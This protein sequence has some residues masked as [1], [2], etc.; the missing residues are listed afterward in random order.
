MANGSIAT[1]KH[2]PALASKP[3][4]AEIVES[5]WYIRFGVW[6]GTL[7][8]QPEIPKGWGWNP[9]VITLCI[10]VLSLVASVSYYMGSANAESKSMMMRLEKAETDAAEAKKL[11]AY[12]AGVADVHSAE[13]KDGK[14]DKEK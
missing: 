14:K 10:V 9:S 7:M 12:Q 2:F 5:P 6:I 8:V 4:E 1:T 3:D 11:S 13:S